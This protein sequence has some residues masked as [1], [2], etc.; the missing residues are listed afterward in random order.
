ME[1]RKRAWVYCYI[2]AP[3]DTHGSLKGQRQQLMDYGL[4]MELEVTGSSS[5]MGEKPLWDRSGFR[6]FMEAVKLGGVD[7]L[8]IA[9]QQCLSRST[10]QMAQFQALAKRYGLEVYSPAEGRMKL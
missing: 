8:L 3:E 10:M 4:Q 1:N 2:D 6:H 9:N 5:D 7:V